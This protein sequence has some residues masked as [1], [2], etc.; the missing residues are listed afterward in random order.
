MVPLT[1][2]FG[3][4]EEVARVQ[5]HVAEEFVHRAVQA[6]RSALGGD[7]DHARGVTVLGG[8]GADLRGEFLDRVGTGAWAE[9][10]GTRYRR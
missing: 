8:R 7:L 9:S 2:G 6:V 3:G 1:V 5:V 10:A 4:Q